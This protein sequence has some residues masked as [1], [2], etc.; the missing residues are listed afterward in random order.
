MPAPSRS[1]RSS[2]PSR[3]S[4]IA[5]AGAATAAEELVRANLDMLYPSSVIEQAY[6]ELKKRPASLRRERTMQ[7]LT[8]ITAFDGETGWALPSA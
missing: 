7:G 1:S 3:R 6:T 8:A 5:E 2:R 4:G